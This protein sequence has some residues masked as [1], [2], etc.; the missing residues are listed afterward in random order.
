MGMG[1]WG[2][3]CLV[4]DFDYFLAEIVGD[5]TMQKFKTDFANCYSDMIRHLKSKLH[6]QGTNEFRISD[7]TPGAV[8]GCRLDA[9]WSSFQEAVEMS[10]F[11]GKNTYQKVFQKAG[12]RKGACI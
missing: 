12:V 2:L 7:Y 6:W 8:E 10:A 9:L 3:Q 11:A 1:S 4:A 5:G